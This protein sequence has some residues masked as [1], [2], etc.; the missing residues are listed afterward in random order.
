[1]PATLPYLRTILEAA[2]ESGRSEREIS[3]MATGQSAAISLI[4]TGRIPSVE[5][6]RRLCHALDLEFY[7][8]PRRQLSPSTPGQGVRQVREARGPRV[9]AMRPMSFLEED[10]PEFTSDSIVVD[11]RN[12]LNVESFHRRY[13]RAASRITTSFPSLVG[14]REIGVD[15]SESRVVF[16]CDWLLQQ[17]IDPTRSVVLGVSGESMAPTVPGGSSVLVD[18]TRATLRDSG[19]FVV[20]TGGDLV[21]K[22]VT[23]DADDRWLLTCDHPEWPAEPWPN[24]AEV[25]GEV[26]WVA[27]LLA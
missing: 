3:R 21:V 24:D 26:R 19:V 22:R 4:K 14:I 17:G 2:R 27:T 20:Q 13:V 25:F 10:R 5:R 16:R 12:V 23:Q 15:G 1:M 11:E 9:D 8:G 6:V 18:C 7:V